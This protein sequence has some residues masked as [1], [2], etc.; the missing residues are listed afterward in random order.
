MVENP[1]AIN[2]LIQECSNC[3]GNEFQTYRDTFHGKV[4]RLGDLRVAKCSDCHGAHRVL[5]ASDP[6]SPTS[7]KR[8]MQTCKKCHPAATAS[9]A[10]YRPH[11]EFKNRQKFPGLYGVYIFMTL[12]LLGV[13]AFFGAHTVLWLAHSIRYRVKRKNPSNKGGD[14][15]R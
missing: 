11:A 7:P 3:H 5:P 4:T 9:F 8:L 6:R 14:D 12:L 15:A 2:A 13:F 10:E 1:A